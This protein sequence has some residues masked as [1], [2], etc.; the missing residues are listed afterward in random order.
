MLVEGQGLLGLDIRTKTGTLFD[1]GDEKFTTTTLAKVGEATA[2]V[3][4]HPAE[5]E[6]QYVQV[7]SF[8]LTQN[9]VR[10]ALERASGSK[11]AMDQMSVAELFAA[12][13]KH[14]SE[15]DWGSAYYKSVTALVYSG[16]E[17]T[18]FP[19]KAEHWDKVLGLGQGETVDEMICRVLANETF[20]VID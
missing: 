12:G 20:Q 3:L 2:A 1:T 13:K 11:F 15:G 18:C 9:L 14:M 16:M 6:N 5:T 17:A 7:K 19:E 10:E 4:L 8:T